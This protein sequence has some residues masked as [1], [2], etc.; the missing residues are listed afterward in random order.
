MIEKKFIQESLKRQKAKEYIKK[1]MAR[2]GIID[3]NI[4][5]T[6][7]NTRII[8]AAERP[9]IVIGR[10]GK[11]ILEL[12]QTI[13]NELGIQNPQIELTDIGNP[14]LEPSVI[15]R[16]IAR[17]LE[18]GY[19]SKRAMQRALFKIKKAGAMGAEIMIRGTMHKGLKAKQERITFGYMKKAGDSVKYIKQAK[20]QAVLKQGVLGITVKIV[21]P[22]VVFPDKIDI[23]EF[24]KKAQPIEEPEKMEDEPNGDSKEE[25]SA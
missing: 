25:G 11:G 9:G 22:D 13:E 6:T 17:M 5:R 15:A 20:T 19:K 23:K 2:A 3:V 14:D 8:I 21:P 10:K 24:I 4:Q 16:W 1:E 7:L 18:R 12:T